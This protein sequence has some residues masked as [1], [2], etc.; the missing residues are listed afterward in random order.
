MARQETAITK[1]RG[2]K[3]TGKGQLVG[4][5][6]QPGLLA[7]ADAFIADQEDA[8]SRPEA[9]RMILEDGPRARGYLGG[10]MMRI[11][12]ATVF[13]L[14]CASVSAEDRDPMAPMQ[15]VNAPQYFTR[16]SLQ[17]FYEAGQLYCDRWD[18]DQHKKDMCLFDQ[19]VAT[20]DVDS[21]LNIIVDWGNDSQ[22]QIATTCLRAYRERL[23]GNMVTLKNCLEPPMNA[24]I[25]TQHNA[26]RT[27]RRYCGE[28]SDAAGGSFVIAEE[29]I[30]QERA[31]RRRL[32]SGG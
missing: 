17:H 13:A 5:R 27:I 28:V 23:D 8:I 11:V 26:E 12:V 16:E 3:P 9:V 18:D 21:A 4:V 19:A 20:W 31:A 14:W 22:I 30:R 25:T 29:C 7:A 24:S 32:R 6:L 10:G 1:R 15:S 2:P